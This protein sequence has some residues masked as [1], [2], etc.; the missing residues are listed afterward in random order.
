[1]VD[2]SVRAY[3]LFATVLWSEVPA[4]IITPDISA[5]RFQAKNTHLRHNNE[6]DFRIALEVMAFQPERMKDVPVGWP[7]RKSV[8]NVE[9][10]LTNSIR[11]DGPRGWMQNGHRS[12]ELV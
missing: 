12:V 5:F 8:K 7:R 11:N 6:V 1:L 9:L 10:C 2:W 3:I 4:R